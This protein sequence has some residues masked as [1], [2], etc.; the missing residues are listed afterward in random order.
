MTFNSR[1]VDDAIFPTIK[2]SMLHSVSSRVHVLPCVELMEWVINH[3]RAQE[4]KIVNE[5]GECIGS[6]LPQDMAYCYK[7]PDPDESLTKYFVIAF[8]EQYDTNKILSSWWKEDMK[9]AKRSSGRYAIS[10]LREPYMY[11]MIL[12]C[13]L[14]GEKTAPNSL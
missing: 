6:F 4:C 13:R 14:Y 1:E 5:Q 8:Y 10:N 3:T 11:V 9:F 7:L 2:R 12:L